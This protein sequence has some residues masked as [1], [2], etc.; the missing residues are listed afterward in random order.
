MSRVNPSN[1][2][3]NPCTRWLEWNGSNGEIRYWDKDSKSL[4]GQ[5]KKGAYLTVKQPFVFLLLE[6]LATI[7][8]W[9]DPSESGIYSN[10]VKDIKAEVLVVKAFKGGEIASGLYSNI[11]D[12]VKAQG[13][14]YVANC[15]IGFK[16]EREELTLGSIQFSGASMNAW[17]EFYKSI[18][19]DAYTK[20]VKISGFTEGRKGA[21]KYCIP[22]FSLVDVT[23]ETD[24]AAG[25]LQNVI[26]NYL[27]AYFSKTRTQQ[28]STPPPSA[29]P[30]I[31]PGGEIP[32][33]VTEKVAESVA[34]IC[35]QCNM[36]I[37]PEEKECPNCA[38]DGVPF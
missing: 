38:S 37:P 31:L 36:P 27:K 17:V 30:S 28:L 6:E 32:D 33:E 18:R 25:V 26:Q 2:L 16:N 8:G 7:K 9:H 35:P 34:R 22:R 4:K 24:D 11:K 19:A 13:G 14:Y 1:V 5:D 23:K 3:P 21:I 12:R 20:A 15:Y 29:E 10:E